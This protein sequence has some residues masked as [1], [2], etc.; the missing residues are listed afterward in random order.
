MIC[1]EKTEEPKTELELSG[2]DVEALEFMHE[3]ERRKT[4]EDAGLNPSEYD[5]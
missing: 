2:L 5:F 1:I 3:S 4:L